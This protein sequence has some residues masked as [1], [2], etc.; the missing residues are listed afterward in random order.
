MPDDRPSLAEIVRRS[1]AMARLSA[2]T[3]RI[4]QEPQ[5]A[6][7]FEQIAAEGEARAD[8]LDALRLAAAA[9]ETE[10]QAIAEHD[11]AVRTLTAPPAPARTPTPSRSARPRRSATGGGGA[12]VT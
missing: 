7:R 9:E 11:A 10:R 6:A 12:S 5:E 8:R 2:D 4:H 3:A 1:A